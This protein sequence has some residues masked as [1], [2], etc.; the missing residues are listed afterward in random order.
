MA[1]PMVDVR[2]V[3][4]SRTTLRRPV[5]ALPRHIPAQA[6]FRPSLIPKSATPR[7]VLPCLKLTPTRPMA[8]ALFKLILTYL[9]VVP[10]RVAF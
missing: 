9:P 1:I 2:R 7:L 3:R 6:L 5:W 4:L 8:P 10:P